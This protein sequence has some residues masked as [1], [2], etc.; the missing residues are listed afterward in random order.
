MGRFWIIVAKNPPASPDTPDLDA[1]WTERPLPAASWPQRS[2]DGRGGAGSAAR[3]AA[4]LTSSAGSAL[5]CMAVL[6]IRGVCSGGHGGAGDRGGLLRRGR[7]CWGGGTGAFS[8]FREYKFLVGKTGWN[9]IYFIQKYNPK[10][11]EIPASLE[12]RGRVT[13]SLNLSDP[14][15]ISD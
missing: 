11:T 4:G 14:C 15:Y 2:A 6:A 10:G 7:R 8:V 3:D 5:A 13:D 1:G 9:T 12:Y